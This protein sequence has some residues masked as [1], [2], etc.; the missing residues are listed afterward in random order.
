MV[1][2]VIH[3][4]EPTSVDGLNRDHFAHA[5]ARIAETCDTPLVIG[6]Y[7]TWG[8]G[9]TSLMKLIEK[10][11]NPMETHSVWFNAWQHQFDETP[12]LALLHTIVDKFKMKQEAKK[13]LMVIAGAF[14][15]MLLKATT[16][17]NI[18]DIDNLGKRYEEERFLVGEAR[19]RLHQHFKHLIKKARGKRRI[20]FFID[21]LDRCMPSKLLNLLESLKLYLNLTGCIYFLGADRTALERSIQ[22]HYKD[23]ELNEARYLD[24]IVQLPFTIPP[25]AQESMEEFVEPL[26]SKNLIHCKKLLIKGLGDNPRQ[27]KRFINT[28]TL[29]HQLALSLNISA[30]NP[31]VLALLLLIQLRNSKL[32]RIIV[33]QPAILQKLKQTSDKTKALRDEYLEKDIKLKEALD[34]VDLPSVGLFSQ[35]IYLTQIA[36]VIKDEAEPEDKLNLKLML[37]DHQKWFYSGG[38]TGRRLNLGG[39]DLIGVDLSKTNLREAAFSGAN[40]SEANLREADLTGAHLSGTKLDGANLQ[41]ALLIGAYPTDARFRKAFLQ[42]ASFQ[43]A[44]LMRAKLQGADFENAELERA[45]LSETDLSEA[46]NLTLEQLSKV[47]T[48]YKAKLDPNIL[49]QIKEKYPHLL[50]K[51]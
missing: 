15:T 10:K 43:G 17:L 14:G 20:V 45:N 32:F 33:N 16:N 31:K 18:K 23:V 34:L 24:K 12:A 49:G 30:Y 5:L 6:L 11:L 50:K 35:Y 13:L 22:Y 29:N 9:K 2:K 38:K 37:S 3:N 1:P 21:D 42:G 39:A 46:E 4:D 41:K 44:K 19:V 28:L 25:I 26:L 51:P 47:K 48:L 8:T 36:R 7:G 40:L 27:V